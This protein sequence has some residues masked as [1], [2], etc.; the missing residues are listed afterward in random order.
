MS[1]L[2]RYG[3]NANGF[4]EQGE[5]TSLQTSTAFGSLRYRFQGVDFK[6]K[7]FINNGTM[8]LQVFTD[9]WVH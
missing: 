9:D 4:N 1:F 5:K 8:I 3:F 2:C 6:G 7:L